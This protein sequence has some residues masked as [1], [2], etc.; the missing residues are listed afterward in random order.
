M[1]P[2]A[3]GSLQLIVAAA[4]WS[5]SGV[6]LK[7][8]PEV[9][10]LAIAAIRSAFGVLVF[11]RGAFLPRPPAGKLGLAVGIWVVM[12]AAL[13][14]SMQLG[15]A[16]QGIWL[17]YLAP[18]VVALWAWLIQKQRLHPAETAAVLLT[19][20]ALA[21][22]V[23]GGSGTRHLQSVG[24]GVVS[25]LTFGSLVIVLKL[26]GD[27]P[28]ASIFLWTNLGATVVLF[29]LL[30]A[31]RIPLPT[32]SGEML[33]LAVMGV[34]QLCLP[35][36]LFKR[37]LVHARAVEASLIS[38][39]EPILNPIWVFLVVG[40]VPS[41]RV[42]LGCALIAVGLVAFAMSPQEKEEP[43]LQDP[44]LASPSLASED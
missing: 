13:M 2:R 10:W 14:G 9:H 17:Q 16:A 5:T 25:G 15:T 4:L 18:A 37:A 3:S 11:A 44:P 40:E 36:Y 19:V 39:L 34:G 27:V 43:V 8:L 29:P 26:L 12:V 32:T 23:T 42:V 20:V 30:F 7:S 24:L 33:L 22:I 6:L 35:Y 38:L 21:L 28:P 31:L 1:N 41:G